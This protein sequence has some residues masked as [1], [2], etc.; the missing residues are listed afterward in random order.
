MQQRVASATQ[1]AQ[2]SQAA[3][4]VR[5]P[6]LGYKTDDADNRPMKRMGY[7]RV[8]GCREKYPNGPSTTGAGGSW[9]SISGTLQLPSARSLAAIGA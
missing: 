1:H 8:V 2:Y 4:D 6:S 7:G 9:F 3:D 5:S